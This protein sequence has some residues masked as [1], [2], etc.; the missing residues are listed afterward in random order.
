MKQNNDINP[1]LGLLAIVVI[2]YLTSLLEQL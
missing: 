1:A 2:Y